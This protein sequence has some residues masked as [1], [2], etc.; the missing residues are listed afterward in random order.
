MNNCWGPSKPDLR[1][2]EGN[3]FSQNWCVANSDR[4]GFASD[5]RKP[6]GV[7]VTQNKARAAAAA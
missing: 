2:G 3:V 1:T 7:V 6:K 5:C 4:G